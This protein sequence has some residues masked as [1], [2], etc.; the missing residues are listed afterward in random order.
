MKILYL[1]A[2]RLPTEKAHGLQIMKTCEALADAGA[3]VELI[4][5]TR[6]TNIKQDE[7]EYYDVRSVFKVTRVRVLDLFKWGKLGFL[8][9]SI[10][11]AEAA[12]LRKE[13]WR[14]MQFI[15]AML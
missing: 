1:A 11:F 2:I 6:H 4:V 14:R 10:L 8:V 15:R 5:P 7:F 13:F 3:E 9:S 12:H